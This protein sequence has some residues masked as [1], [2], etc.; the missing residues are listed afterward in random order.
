MGFWEQLPD[1]CPPAG[2]V[3]EAI[4]NAYRIVFSNPATLEHFKS[5]AA[6]G[7][8]KPPSVDSCRFSSCSLFTE[9]LVAKNVANLPKMRAKNPKIAQVSVPEGSGAW[10]QQ[11]VHVDLW[12][13]DHFDPVTAVIAV[14]EV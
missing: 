11:G 3:E 7:D 1:Q 6:R 4:D 9:H 10:I 5:H 14:E 8:K 2:F 12:I 13:Y